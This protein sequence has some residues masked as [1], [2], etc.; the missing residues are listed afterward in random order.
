MHEFHDQKLE[1]YVECVISS[2]EAARTA[3]EKANKQRCR[4]IDTARSKYQWPCCTRRA[5][6]RQLR[7]VFGNGALNLRA[8]SEEFTKIHGSQFSNGDRTHPSSAGAMI[9]SG[10]SD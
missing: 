5:S 6:L 2:F 1:S 7:A 10:P 8:T 4:F 9:T 3:L